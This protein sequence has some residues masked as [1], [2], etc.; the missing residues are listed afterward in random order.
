MFFPC[1]NYKLQFKNENYNLE[2]KQLI[3]KEKLIFNI[4]NYI[5]GENINIIHRI[6]S[7]NGNTSNEPIILV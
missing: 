7:F 2:T 5:K 3:S 4:Q 6:E 1:D